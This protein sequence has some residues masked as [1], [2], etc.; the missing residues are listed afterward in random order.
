MELLKKY[1]TKKKIFM[2]AFIYS[3]IYTVL[4]LIGELMGNSVSSADYSSMTTMLS[5]IASMITVLQIL[6][7]IMLVAAVI[8]A[9]LAGVYFFTKDKSD[10]VML[11]EF[12]GYVIS[13]ALLAFSISGVNAICK[14][15]KIYTS[16]DYTSALSMDYTSMMSSIET[17]GNCLNYFKWVMIILFIA[18]LFIFLVMK[19]IIKLSN[20]SY[21]LVDGVSIG[22]RKVVSY[23]PQTGKPIYEEVS[24]AGNTT[25]S[26]GEGLANVKAFFKT[27][28]GKITLGVIAA[29]IIA[30]G[31]YKIYDTYFNKTAI[32]LLGNV[33]VEFAGYDGAGRVTSCRMGDVE[34]DKTNAEIASFINS[35]SLDYKNA[36]NLKNGDE[37]KVTA[38]YN[39]TTAEEL[40]LDVQDATVT[41]KVK[42]LTERYKKASEVPNKTSSAIK[43]L[44]DEEMKK[45][46][47]SRQ[48]NY[49]S[50]KTSFISMY[51]AYDEENG[52]SPSDYCIGVYKVEYNSNYG[53]TPKTETYYAIAY[54]SGINSSYSTK[55]KKSI[56]TTNLYSS[57][58]EKLTDESQ[59]QSVLENSYRFD[60]HKISKFK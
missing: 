39:Q 7:Y 27:K 3:G 28:N 54:I 58:Y 50:Y 43:K 11:G 47:D 49:Y 46:Y 52:Y 42:G 40:K 34:Y 23:D 41:V 6:F 15:V 13:S 18:N 45:D 21:N 26:S 9:V 14:V 12:I 16:G 33:E 25:V 56:Y 4:W 32:S 19:N 24:V 44:M 38:V 1:A 29:V 20:F 8:I 59:I 22:E 2:S 55:E 60:D 35:V 53:S 10:Y 30:F 48:S 37:I 5:T 17:A 57:G 31:G 51:Y 36:D